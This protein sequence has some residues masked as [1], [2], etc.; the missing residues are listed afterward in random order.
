[1]PYLEFEQQL[2]P[3]G[4]GIVTIGSAPEAG[5]RILGRDLAPIHVLIAPQAEGRA[6]VVRGSTSAVVAINGKNIGEERR[7]IAFG[8]SIRI[9]KA[10]FVYRQTARQEPTGEAFLRD[11]RRSRVF[12]LHESAMIG[13]DPKC[14]VLLPEASV[15]RMHAELRTVDGQYEV[16]PVGNAYVALN[17]EPVLAPAMLK[18]G[19][20][21]SIGDTV[22]RFTTERPNNVQTAQNGPTFANPRAAA[23]ATVFVGA[24]EMRERMQRGRQRKLAAVIGTAVAMIVLIV[25]IVAR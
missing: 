20:E 7:S 17:H 24:V 3:V 22:L 9:G 11:M 8:D 16:K 5:W 19:D 4:P 25:L 6:L 18:E 10:E 2:R 21:L 1:M 13:R 23:M 12:K 14:A 15:S